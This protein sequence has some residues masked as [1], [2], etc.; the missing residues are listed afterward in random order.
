MHE[1]ETK[2]DKRQYWAWI[3]V[4]AGIRLDLV[5]RTLCLPDKFRISLAAR[6]SP[7]RSSV[8]AINVKDQH[9]VIHV[10]GFM[11]VRIGIVTS[12]SNIWVRND[13]T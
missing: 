9:V 10:G 8:Q 11:E 4:P 7:Y 13:A 1:S 6:R 5:D 2:L 3:M 12:K